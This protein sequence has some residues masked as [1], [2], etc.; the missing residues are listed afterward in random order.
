MIIEGDEPLMNLDYLRVAVRRRVVE[1]MTAVMTQAVSDTKRYKLINEDTVW[2]NGSM[3]VHPRLYREYHRSSTASTIFPRVDRGRTF[4][5][6]MGE[7]MRRKVKAL[8]LL[9]ALPVIALIGLIICLAD[10][11]WREV[12]KYWWWDLEDLVYDILHELKKGD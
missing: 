8:L 9:I 12:L 2:E 10:W 4:Y 5:L 11:L 3:S 1:G 6:G 7:S